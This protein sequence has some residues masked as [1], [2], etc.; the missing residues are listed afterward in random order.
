MQKDRVEDRPSIDAL[1]LSPEAKKHLEYVKGLD[2]L[3]EIRG[4]KKAQQVASAIIDVLAVNDMLCYFHDLV[5]N[6]LRVDFDQS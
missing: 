2:C 6:P 4:D 5:E 3:A 1:E